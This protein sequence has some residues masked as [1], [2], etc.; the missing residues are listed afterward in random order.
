MG[1][2]SINCVAGVAMAAFAVMPSA[3]SVPR[4]ARLAAA[5]H[6]GDVA[7]ASFDNDAALAGYQRAFAIDSTDC[8][9]LWKLARSNVNHGLAAPED[10]RPR[11]FASGED[12]ARRCVALYPDTAEAHFFL[13]VAIGQMTKVV[14]GKRKI[15]L[16]KDVKSEAEAALALD[17]AH[18]GAM[19]ILGRWNYEI[20]GLGWFSK[21]A[22]KIVYGGVPPGAT[23][24]QAREWFERA[25]VVRPDM[26]LNHLWLGETLVKLDDYP[27]ARTELQT[28]LALDDVLWDDSHTRTRAQKLLHDIEGKH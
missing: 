5:L 23:Y 21:V 15:E 26:P 20:A 25:I 8:G 1:L 9:V 24:Q 14:G 7:F 27:G 6:D 22:A 11:W 4:E 28:C 10:E 18:A 3:M 19:H 17:P 13:A 16:S 2:W 12:L